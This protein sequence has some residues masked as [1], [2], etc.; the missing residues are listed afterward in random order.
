MMPC[1]GIDKFPRLVPASDAVGGTCHARH[2]GLRDCNVA[3]WRIP[4]AFA[5]RDEWQKVDEK[6]PLCG[7][8]LRLSQP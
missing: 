8:P 5:V 4:A 6:R 1:R 7:S 2:S 3:K